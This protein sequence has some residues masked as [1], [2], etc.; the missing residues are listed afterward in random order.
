MSK[1]KNYLLNEETNE[2]ITHL[3]SL[4]PE[5]KF[6]EELDVENVIAILA[7]YHGMNEKDVINKLIT[8]LFKVLCGDCTQ[9]LVGKHNDIPDED[10]NQEELKR[11]I[12]IEYEHTQIPWIAKSIA[13]DHI[14]ETPKGKSYYLGLIELEKKLGSKD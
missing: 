13:K 7:R 5:R 2:F 4:L 9:D 1:L 14:M 8:I 12:E 6:S 3:I 11:G 10:F